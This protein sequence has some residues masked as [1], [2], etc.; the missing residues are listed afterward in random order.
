MYF[1]QVRDRLNTLALA[2]KL[3]SEVI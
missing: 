1:D 2:D 3:D